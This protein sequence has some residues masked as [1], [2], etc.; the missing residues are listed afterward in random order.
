[1]LGARH[2]CGV[3]GSRG[4]GGTICGRTSERRIPMPPPLHAPPSAPQDTVFLMDLRSLS[5]LKSFAYR[6]GSSI[7]INNA[8]IRIARRPDPLARALVTHVLSIADP[9]PNAVGAEAEAE[10]KQTGGKAGRVC[11]L[12]T[13][14]HLHVVSLCGQRICLACAA[15]TASPIVASIPILSLSPHAQAT[16]CSTTASARSFPTRA[17]RRASISCRRR[18]STSSGERVEVAE[19]QFSAQ[20]PVGWTTAVSRA[21]AGLCDQHHPLPHR[22][23]PIRVSAPGTTSS[24]PSR[25][26]W[27]RCTA[28]SFGARGPRS[29]RAR[30]TASSRC[31]PACAGM[32]FGGDGLRCTRVG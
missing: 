13:A 2:R 16:G 21:C 19:M 11:R 17:A 24:A 15:R 31:V 7:L 32:V 1:M 10:M 9:R 18:R 23:Q 22:L 5:E 3:G 20:V 29:F 28:R 12:T 30:G 6:A 26:K 25:S 27:R 14:S 4:S 8:A